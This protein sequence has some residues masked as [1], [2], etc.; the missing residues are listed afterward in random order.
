MTPEQ[1]SE[2]E[3]R[4]EE[5][6]EKLIGGV[7]AGIRRAGGKLRLA[8][9]GSIAE[10]TQLRKDYEKEMKDLSLSRFIKGLE[11]IF[12]VEADPK[13]DATAAH[14]VSLVDPNDGA[15]LQDSEMPAEITKNMSMKEKW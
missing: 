1:V 11:E 4:K 7:K 5:L 13:T 14:L 10:V 12:K 2:Q 9:C 8:Q 15:D 6:S 3:K